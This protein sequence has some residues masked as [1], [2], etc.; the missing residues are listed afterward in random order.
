M[1]DIRFTNTGGD[2]FSASNEQGFVSI[3]KFAGMHAIQFHLRQAG[4][5]SVFFRVRMHLCMNIGDDGIGSISIVC[6][7]KPR[8]GFLCHQ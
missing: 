8:G 2:T 5:P 7:L 1:S 4:F 6:Q 3:R